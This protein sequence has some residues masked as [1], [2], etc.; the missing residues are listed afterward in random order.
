M[1]CWTNRLNLTEKCIGMTRLIRERMK[2]FGYPTL[3][4]GTSGVPYY[5]L[6]TMDELNKFK[7]RHAGKR[8]YILGNG[9]SLRHQDLSVLSGEITFGVNGIFLLQGELGF[10]PTY[11]LVEDWLPAEDRADEINAMKGTIKFFPL[12][13]AYC[14]L[15]GPDVHYYHTADYRYWW[16]PDFSTNAAS[17][18]FDSH[19]VIYHALQWAFFMGF[20]EVCLLGVDLSYQI[21]ADTVREGMVFTSTTDDPNHF[22]KRYFGRGYRWHNPLEHAML[23]SFLAADRAYQNDGRQI[24]NVGYGGRLDAFPRVPLP[25]MV[26][27]PVRNGGSAPELSRKRVLMGLRHSVNPVAVRLREHLLSRSL[28][29]VKEDMRE[30]PMEK[31]CKT[32]EPIEWGDFSHTRPVSNQ[33]G[34]DRGTP[35][36]R[37][38]VESF[39]RLNSMDIRGRCIELLNDN[40]IR[41]FGGDKV[42]HKDV[43]DINPENKRATVVTD[44]QDAATIPN[45]TYDCFI[46]TQTLHLIPDFIRA[47]R[48][49]RRILKPGGIILATVPAISRIDNS[50]TV[51]RDYWRFTKAGAQAAFERV[52]EKCQFDVQS[53]GNV[54]T[55]T[56]FWQGLAQEEM[57]PE[58]FEFNDPD[59]PVIITIRAVKPHRTNKGLTRDRHRTTRRNPSCLVLGYHRVSDL[60]LDSNQL[61]VSPDI[62]RGHLDILTNEYS[63][64]SP[65]EFAEFVNTGDWPDRPSILLTFDDGYAPECC[66]ALRILQ[67]YKLPAIFLISSGYIGADREFWWDDLERLV[68]TGSTPDVFDRLECSDIIDVP[69]NTGTFSQRYVFYRALQSRLKK[70]NSARIDDCL[71]SLRKWAQAFPSVRHTHRTIDADQLKAIVEIPGME[72][73]G[74]GLDHLKLDTLSHDEQV[75]QIWEDRRRLTEILGRD[76]R[77]FAYPFGC[78]CDELDLILR[79]AGYDFAFVRDQK[80]VALQ[81]LNLFAL[82][83]FRCQGWQPEIFRGKVD[84][85]L[86]EPTCSSAPA[87]SFVQV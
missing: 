19:T 83:R 71:K 56:A 17:C 29:Q 87:A 31:S 77:Y 6:G 59:F 64:I 47:I 53:F 3:F 49:A 2:Y 70:M 11:Y 40:Y 84:E 69:A 82:S 33:Y 66:D 34:F 50:A 65:A 60:D 44:L 48:E 41:R 37:Y 18:V 67:E 62:F 12:R 8:C 79:E 5:K 63:V 20:S 78:R 21:P 85:V 16:D 26:K 57:S 7:D 22:D 14:L 52:F 58:D 42:T 35:V 32:A 81:S 46:L 74:H 4:R 80:G 9:P 86:L 36:D 43:L 51:E 38:Y 27:R 25:E 45:N 23:A 39:L 54:K 68:L 72:V 30:K 73:G 24:Y 55:G 15:P 28:N 13:L 76:L 61:A 75:H 10:L 1:R